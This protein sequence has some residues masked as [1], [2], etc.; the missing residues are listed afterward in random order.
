MKAAEEKLQAKPNAAAQKREWKRQRG[1]QAWQKSDW[2]TKAWDDNK[3]GKKG[4]WGDNEDAW[5][6]YKR[7]R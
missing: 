6:A 5:D 2:D 1:D 3:N 4:K 7:S